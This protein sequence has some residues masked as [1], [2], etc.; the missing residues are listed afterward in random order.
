MSIFLGIPQ[1]S[2]ITGI[3]FLMINDRAFSVDHMCKLF[4][5]DNTLGDVDSDINTLIKR[6]FEKL[7]IFKRI[8]LKPV[9]GQTIGSL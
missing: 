1:G 4:S 7:K 5:D 2:V 6:F 8:R 3:F 9:K